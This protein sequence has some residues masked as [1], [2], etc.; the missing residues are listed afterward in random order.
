M[1]NQEKDII[2]IDCGHAMNTAGKQTPLYADGSVIKE[3]E[4][5]YRVGKYFDKACKRCGFTTFI[6]HKNMEYED[7]DPNKALNDRID[8]INLVS[9][10]KDIGF[11]F[12]KNASNEYKWNN[13]RGTQAHIYQL[14]GEEERVSQI[15][16]DTIIRRTGDIDRGL[17]DGSHLGIVAKTTPLMI[18]L[19]LGFM[20]NKEDAR[21]MRSEQA[22][23]LYAESV[24]EGLCLATGYMYQKELPE[25]SEWAEEA[26]QWVYENGISDGTRPKDTVTREEV[27]TMLYRYNNL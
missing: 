25:C 15:V 14:G 8:K 11:S 1:F 17:K 10:S 9:E 5:N 19:E 21:D 24:C 27:W 4:Q 23:K 16:L 18:L 7:P 20:T 3:A 22:C 6:S 2:V 13:I 12:H 26:Q